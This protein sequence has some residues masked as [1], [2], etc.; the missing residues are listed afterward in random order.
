MAVVSAIF[1][2][3]D[4]S[5]ERQAGVATGQSHS[6]RCFRPVDLLLT[7]A[8]R[9]AAQQ[10]RLGEKAIVGGF[11]SGIKS[12][13]EVETPRFSTFGDPVSDAATPPQ[14]GHP[15]IAVTCS[16]CICY[17]FPCSHYPSS[18]R[19]GIPSAPSRPRLDNA[20]VAGAGP[21]LQ[22]VSTICGCSSP[23]HSLQP[24]L[25]ASPARSTGRKTLPWQG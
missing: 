12:K 14:P 6:F 23:R 22:C 3:V 7:N 17:T 10:R 25:F 4:V 15:S 24:C 18:L 1:I 5:T 8:G 11:T 19:L 21:T 13:S 20:H 2:C 16:Y 9:E